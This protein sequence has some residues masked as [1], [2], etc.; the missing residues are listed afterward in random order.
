MA[1]NIM[2]SYLVVVGTQTWSVNIAVVTHIMVHLVRRLVVSQIVV[3]SKIFTLGWC[4]KFLSHTH[5][6]CAGRLVR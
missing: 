1:V 4:F 2:T 3:G 5:W 6:S